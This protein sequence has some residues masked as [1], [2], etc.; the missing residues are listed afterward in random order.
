[1]PFMSDFLWLLLSDCSYFSDLFILYAVSLSPK[2]VKNP[3]PRPDIPE[4][5]RYKDDYK[6]AKL[7]SEV[8][9]T[10]S[11]TWVLVIIYI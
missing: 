10:S 4:K 11:A 5:A 6:N 7:V 1:M 9:R 8:I 2:K 3:F